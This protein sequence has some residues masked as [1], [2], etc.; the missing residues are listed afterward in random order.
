MSRTVFILGAGASRQAGGPL[1]ADFLDKARQLRREGRVN[2]TA[3]DFDLVFK[4]LASLDVVHAKANISIDNFE[5]VFGLFEMG[6]LCGRLGRLSAEEIP[7]AGV[8]IRR[9]I[10]KTLEVA[11]PL[12]VRDQAALAPAPYGD[13]ITLAGLIEKA[14]LGPVSYLTFNYDVSLDYAL[15]RARERVDYCLSSDSRDG[16]PVMKLH[17]S[18]NWARCQKCAQIVP[19]HLREFLSNRSWRPFFEET[20]TA[21]LNI[22]SSLDQFN[23]CDTACARE[24]VLVPPTWNKARYQ[25]L[26][27]VWQRAAEHLSEAENI[28]VVGFSLPTTDEFFRFLFALGTVGDARIERFWVFDPADVSPRFRDLLGATARTR[29]Q[30]IGCGFDEAIREIANRLGLGG[31]SREVT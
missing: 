23:H 8:A 7:K 22:G 14:K 16:V 13:L 6:A 9:L 4:T 15:H 2:D 20:K 3:A 12:P 30:W 17:G 21:T 19:W 26:N 27:S 24:P 29:F 10:V 11:I 18:L 31:V 5:Q 1:M 28:F 25:E